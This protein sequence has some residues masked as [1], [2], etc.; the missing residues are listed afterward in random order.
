VRFCFY[1]G[2]TCIVS[3]IQ[4]MVWSSAL[5]R[6]EPDREVHSDLSSLMAVGFWLGV[7]LNLCS[8]NQC[9]DLGKERVRSK[10]S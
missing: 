3:L 2:F 8:F 5:H 1:F 7:P 6:N 10:S 9:A 4:L